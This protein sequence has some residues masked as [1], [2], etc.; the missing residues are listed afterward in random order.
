MDLTKYSEKDLFLTAM[1]NEIDAGAIYSKLAEMVKNAYLKDKL[2]FL[3]AEEEKHQ[4]YLESAFSDRFAGEEIQLPQNS[5]VPLPELLI[6]DETVP[7]STVIQSAMDAEGAAEEFYL[8]FASRF[9]ESSNNK[10]TLELFAS[11]E[12]GHYKI[13]EIEKENI[14]KFEEY[15]DYWPMMHMGT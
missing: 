7:L 10:K 14:E 2:R 8:A 1:R 13:L 3:A 4:K 11:M 6:P 15:D 5:I 12:R 9:D